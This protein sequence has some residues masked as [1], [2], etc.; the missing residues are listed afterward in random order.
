MAHPCMLPSSKFERKSFW[1]TESVTAMV[2]GELFAPEAVSVIVPL[3]V[4]MAS[5]AV[6]AVTVMVDGAVPE[7]GESVSH[8]TLA[9]AVQFNV[10]PPRLLTVS[11]WLAG[12]PCP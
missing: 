12:F 8:E 9:L 3:Y 6:F 2:G 7:A 1:E 5:P 4:P 10:F 11:C